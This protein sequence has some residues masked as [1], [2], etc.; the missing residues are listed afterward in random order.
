M[1]LALLASMARLPDR[2]QA[3][4]RVRPLP[5]CPVR[6]LLRKSFHPRAS[7]PSL[8]LRVPLQLEAPN[9]LPEAWLLLASHPR[10]MTHPGLSLVLRI[11]SFS[12]CPRLNRSSNLRQ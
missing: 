10:L 11:L 7:R 6:A 9:Q 12:G 3:L 5:P 4:S 2:R 1:L 8:K